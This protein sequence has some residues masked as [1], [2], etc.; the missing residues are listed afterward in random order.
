M[1]N[2]PLYSVVLVHK[3]CTSSIFSYHKNLIVGSTKNFS[4]ALVYLALFDVVMVLTYVLV[5]AVVCRN[6]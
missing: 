1:F 5:P 3:S 4:L 6:C 2:L